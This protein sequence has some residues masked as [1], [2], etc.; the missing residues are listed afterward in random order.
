M[1][2]HRRT[3]PHILYPIL[4]AVGVAGIVLL[5]RDEEAGP[6]KLP[7]DL[8]GAMK[9]AVAS[10]K[11]V[12]VEQF[13]QRAGFVPVWKD[14]REEAVAALLTARARGLKPKEYLDGLNQ[15]GAV[16]DVALTQG[17]MRYARD[18]RFGRANPGIYGKTEAASL[19]DL[20]WSLSQDPAGLEAGL[21]K[22]DPPFAEYKRLE[23]ALAQYRLK[24]E[25]DVTALEQVQQIERTLERWRWLP[26]SFE[27]GAILVNVPEFRLRAMDE[28]NQV[29]L[30]MRA[31]V[32]LPTHQTPLF[33]G[34][35]KYLVFGPYWNVPAS[36]LANELIPDI[37]K[38]RSYLARNAYEVVNTEGHVVSTGEVS[39]EV[40]TGLR[41][42]QL[43]VRQV[44][45]PK[46][47]L[48]KVKFMFP[49]QN[50]V[51][52][53]DTSNR[54]LFAKEQRAMSHGCVRVEKPQEL[55]EWV[56]RGQQDWP[57]DRIALG[58]KQTKP[59][60]ANLKQPIPV[61]MLYHTVTVSED[62]EIHFWKDIYKQDAPA[63]TAGP[64]P[65]PRE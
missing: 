24:A 63:T 17:L 55:A 26:R 21:E 12:A 42:G 39:D 57:A 37:A 22:L 51:Y 30:E 61:F 46:N 14:R 44:P 54:N 20:A 3:Y 45:G 38:D 31:I 48:G 10:A 9:K 35:L 32:G 49:N 47:A 59:L 25:V 62:G 16:A 40:L 53:H 43:S 52:L 65:R 33:T 5:R 58:M 19:S 6:T 7:E 27:R 41:S 8:T 13:Y 18:V 2:P 29:A 11:D 56:L 4:L 1:K 34:N 50:S 23:T 60:Q 64:G 15:D 36:I 28:N